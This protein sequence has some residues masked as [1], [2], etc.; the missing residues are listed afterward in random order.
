MRRPLIQTE[1]YMFLCDE[2]ANVASLLNHIKI[3]MNTLSDLTHNL[4]GLIISV[5]LIM[6]LLM[7]KKVTYFGNLY[8]NLFSFAYIFT[9]AVTSASSA[10]Y[11]PAN[12]PPLC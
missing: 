4:E 6:R 7:K 10:A 8:F 11:H 1:C 9:V 5:V 3:Q 12:R 2:S